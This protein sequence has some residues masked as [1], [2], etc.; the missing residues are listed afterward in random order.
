MKQIAIIAP[1]ASGKTS[2]SISIAHKTNS[3]ILSLDSLALYKQ[4]DIASAKPTIKER[5]GIVHFGIDEVFP[6]EQFDVMNFIEIYKKAYDYAKQN[7]KNLI[8][9]G[10]TGFYLKSL[11]E[12]IS[13]IPPLSKGNK[14]IL[15][16]KMTTFTLSELYIYLERID[17]QYMANIK[18]NDKY[19]VEKALSIYLQ[20]KQK[21]SEFFRLN[22]PI[23]IIKDIKLFSIE[24]DAEFL[25]KRISQRTKIMIEDGLIDEVVFLE[26]KYKRA[27]SPMGSIGIKEGLDYLDGKLTKLELEEKISIAT[28]QLAKRQRTFNKGQF[29]NVTRDSLSNLEI[30]ILK[31]YNV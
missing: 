16:E 27:I 26:Q 5:D 4:I 7:N 2:L 6:N 28:A 9:V 21:P 20:T 31:D 23:P 13:Y 12:G 24:W 15:D 25:R 8:I 3:I 10:G 11:I 14:K 17:S 29:S 30:K 19:R 18:S 22:P 1:T